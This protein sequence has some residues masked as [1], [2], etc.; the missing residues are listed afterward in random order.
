MFSLPRKKFHF[1]CGQKDH[2][3]SQAS[4]LDN[5]ERRRSGESGA[6]RLAGSPNRPDLTR[7]NTK[8][9]ATHRHTGNGSQLIPA[10]QDAQ[11]IFSPLCVYR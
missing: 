9:H 2:G 1:F 10:V 3:P 7:A 8:D 11:H 4:G 5:L 6:R